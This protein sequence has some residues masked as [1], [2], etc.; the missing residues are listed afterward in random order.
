MKKEAVL[1]SACRVAE[2]T[3]ASLSQWFET[4]L[5]RDSTYY[6]FLDGEETFAVVELS[7]GST[8]SGPSYKRRKDQ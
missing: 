4:D 2:W 5:L 6:S 1:I 7:D 3:V 8:I